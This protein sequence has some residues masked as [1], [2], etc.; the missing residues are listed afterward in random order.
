MGKK[1]K[2]F[3]MSF[4]DKARDLAEKTLSYYGASLNSYIN[5]LGRK[6]TDR[7]TVG[8]FI[9]RKDGKGTWLIEDGGSGNVYSMLG[10]RNIDDME[11]LVSKLGEALDKE[12]LEELNS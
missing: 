9:I 2:T 11:Y 12:M 5:Y 7:M 4:R 6:G 3:A 10:P 1:R 8:R